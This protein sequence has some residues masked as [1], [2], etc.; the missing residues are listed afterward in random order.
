MI[1]LDWLEV[2]SF[3][4]LREIRIEF[5]ARGAVLIE[6]ANESG[7]ST[8]FESA[9][10]GL[11]GAGLVT[12][13]NRRSLES[14]IM[15]GEESASVRLGL[16]TSDHSLRIE[17]TIR[18]SG[19]NT[20]ALTVHAAGA[21]PERITAV[22]EV[23]SRVVEELGGLD[24]AALLNSCF[25]EQK[26]LGKL[27]DM[28]AAERRESLLRILN[29][30]KLSRLDE[31]YRIRPA[32]E[33]AVRQGADRAAAARAR[34][35]EAELRV[36]AA[37]LRASLDQRNRERVLQAVHHRENDLTALAER[38]AQLEQLRHIETR[39]ALDPQHTELRE[40]QR[41]IDHLLARRPKIT[42]AGLAGAVA[43]LLFMVIALL[44][45]SQSAA[46][47]GGALLLGVGAAVRYSVVRTNRG[48][49]A[50]RDASVYLRG[51]V[52][53]ADVESA[54]LRGSLAL[55][56]AAN[57]EQALST[58][59]REQGAAEHALAQLRA[60]LAAAPVGADHGEPQD[61]G[62]PVTEDALEETEERLRDLAAQIRHLATT[63]PEPE[64]LPDA[65]LLEAEHA[66]AVHELEVRRHASTI[67]AEARRRMV[68]RVLPE[69]ERNMTMILPLL[70]A[71]R[72]FHARITED[73]RIDLWDE[74]AGRYVG[75]NVYSGGTKDQISLA[76][77]LAFAIASLPQEMGS[78]PGFL[79]MDEPLSSFDEERTGALVELI[80]TGELAATF[81]Q[82]FIISHSRSFNPGRFPHVIHME[83]GDIQYTTLGP[84]PML[85]R[86]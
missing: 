37:R 45:G 62:T 20:A 79:F 80:T 71:G 10:F 40:R 36:H 3:K 34:Q 67:L 43:L 27:E 75:K 1:T 53:H 38:A 13:D 32:D 31:Q 83:N 5:P 81:P 35:D 22:R 66:G 73:Y 21:A 24:G 59:N 50:A 86:R 9:Y 84:A 78:S 28:G 6:G 70:T 69:T 65:A 68:D 76:L 44:A 17:R 82:I 47:A 58:A 51:A 54:R 30:D 55:P 4:S 15:Y 41:A 77:R 19:R 57:I 25:V 64:A 16:R 23:H 48:I 72:Y 52:R 46:L 61:S 85:A 8:L 33:T 7:K 26:K 74:G 11:Y 12:E 39:R 29:L 2:T 18:R 63:V 14:L 42:T 60:D 56:P 49:E